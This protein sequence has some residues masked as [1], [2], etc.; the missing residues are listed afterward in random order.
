VNASFKFHTITTYPFC[1]AI[2]AVGEESGSKAKQMH[3]MPPTTEPLSRNSLDETFVGILADEKERQRG[4][5]KERQGGAS[6][7]QPR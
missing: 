3:R 4:N 5:E 1:Q 6:A 7:Q 2:P